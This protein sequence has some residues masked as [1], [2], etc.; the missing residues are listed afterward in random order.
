MKEKIIALQEKFGV[1]NKFMASILG[2][3]T[4]TYCNKKKG[5]K[6]YN[7]TEQEYNVIY[8]HYSL[9]IG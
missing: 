5:K 8:K 3:K 7:F 9:F 1:T 6:N 2:I 4:Q